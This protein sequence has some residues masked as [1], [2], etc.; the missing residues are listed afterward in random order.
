M[1]HTLALVLGGTTITVSSGNYTLLDYVPRTPSSDSL[2]VTE[3]ARVYMTAASK[4]VL[5]TAI[6]AIEDLFSLA[7]RRQ[8]TGVGNIGYVHLTV[9]GDSTT[10]RSEILDGSLLMGDDG[11]RHWGNLGTEVLLTW[12]RRF[13]WEGDLTTLGLKRTG[14]S[15]TTSGV[16]IYNH[17]DSTT[18]ENF[19]DI[20]GAD[21]GG[22]LPSPLY[23]T[24]VPGA[25]VNSRR[26]YISANTFA[27]PSDFVAILEGEDS[28]GGGTATVDANSSDGYYMARS[29]TPSITHSTNAFTWA[30]TDAMMQ[31][32]AGS[33]LR[34]LMRSASAPPA[35]CYVQLKIKYSAASPL[36]TLWEGPEILLDTNRRLHDLG[37][38]PLPP[39]SSSGG[40]HANL[41]LILSI[42]N[43]SAAQLDLDYL[44]LSGPDGVHRFDQQGYTF[45]TIDTMIV[46]G[47]QDVVFI[48]SYN[49]SYNQAVYIISNYP[50]F[51]MLHPGKNCRLRVLFDEASGACVIS[52]TL[53]L[54][55]KYRPR[56][57]TV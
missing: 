10:W 26:F 43:S 57:V 36:T 49:G 48:N 8:I 53:R 41:A 2:D 51:V 44:Q 1:A 34:V 4:T 27:E 16:T 40:L 22:S 29:W 13:Y 25:A 39:G 20:E 12:T 33:W 45:E 55:A 50:P 28:T 38:V 56:R 21:I 11:L 5:Q 14:V 24:M 3:S 9:D 47:P 46:D 6:R 42:R 52:R 37:S 35:S 19:V 32:T 15:K 17:H 31:D 30:I 18:H 7:R 54:N 23:L